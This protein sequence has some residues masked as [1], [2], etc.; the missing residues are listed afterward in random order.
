MQ[1]QTRFTQIAPPPGFT[2]RVMARLAEHERARARRRALIGSGLLVGVAGAV[3]TLGALWLATWVWALLATPHVIVFLLEGLG[4]LA[5]WLRA[6]VGAGWLAAN[7]V[8]A[9]LD[10]LA[11]TGCAAGVFGLTWL[12]VRIVTGSFQ[13]SLATISAGGFSK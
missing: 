12:W 1:N 10:P 6:V 13:L 11:M 9:Q 3:L 2:G 7:V 4:T 5:F 8:V